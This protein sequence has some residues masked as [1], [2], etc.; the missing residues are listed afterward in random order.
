MNSNKYE[1][2]IRA[3][4]NGVEKVPSKITWIQGNDECLATPCYKENDYLVV[5]LIPDCVGNACI[6]GYLHFDDTCTNCE[7]EHFKRCFCNT[8]ADCPDCSQCDENYG[9]CVDQCKEGE[10]CKDDACIECDENTPCPNNQICI[11][12]HCECPPNMFKDGN[13]CVE[14][15]STTNL[16]K[17][18]ECINGVITPKCDKACIELTGECVD[19]IGSGDCLDRTDGKNCCSDNQCDCCNGF[20]WDNLLK[21]CVPSCN[22]TTCNE[23]ERCTK[24]GCQPIQ[25]PEGYKCYK[26]ECVYW[27]CESVSCDNGAECGPECGC[28][29]FEGVKQCVPCYILECNGLCEQALGCKCNGTKCESS[30]NCKETYC[31]NE[32]PCEDP[33][34]TC[35]D[36]KCVDCSNFPCVDEGGCSSYDNCGCNE[37]NK[38]EGTGCEGGLTLKKEEDCTSTTGC[39]LKAEF[40]VKACKCDP[41]VF[42]TKNTVTCTSTSDAI[43]LKVELFKKVNGADIPYSSYKTSPYFA[44]DELVSTQIRTVAEYQYLKDGKFYSYSGTVVTSPMPSTGIMNNVISNLVLNSSHIKKTITVGGVSYPAKVTIKV[45]ADA[46]KIQNANCTKYESTAKIAEYVLDYS[47]AL[48]TTDTCNKINTTYKTEQVISVIDDK[49]AKRPR[50]TWYRSNTSTFEDDEFIYD[51]TYNESGW[52]RKSFGTL[53]SGKWIDEINNTAKFE[54]NSKGELL[55]NYNY[56]VKADCGCGTKVDSLQ[57]VHFC[58]PKDFT[59]TITPCDKKIVINPFSVCSINDT[60]PTSYSIPTECQVK[61]N[62][63]VLLDSGAVIKSQLPKS[64]LTKTYPD[65]IVSAKI[66]QFNSGGIL[67]EEDYCTFMLTVPE[68]TLP[69]PTI[70]VDCNSVTDKFRVTFTQTSP[71]NI[72]KVEVLANGIKLTPEIFKTTPGLTALYDKTISNSHLPTGEDPQG[73]VSGV[74]VKLQARVTFSNGCSK[75]IDLTPCNPSLTVTENPSGATSR[76]NCPQG[77]QGVELDSYLEGFDMS[78]PVLFTISGGTLTEPL[79]NGTGTF[80]NLGAGTYTVVATQGALTSTATKTIF[81]ATAPTVTLTSSIC[82]GETGTL[83]ITAPA[84]SI[85]SVMGPTGSISIPPI[86]QS[87]VY[88]ITGLTASGTYTITGGIDNNNQT[89]YPFTWT[90]NMVL[91]GQVLNPIFSPIAYGNYCVD[92]PIEIS[93]IDG[94]NGKIYNIAAISGYITDQAGNNVTQMISGQTYFYT[95]TSIGS[96]AVQIISIDSTCDTLLTTPVTRTFITIVPAPNV[97][98]IVVQCV[99]GLYNVSATVTV[100]SG[101]ISS[102]LISGIPA[103]NIGSTYSVTGVPYVENLIATSSNGCIYQAILPIANCNCPS[104]TLTITGPIV[105]L[106]GDQLITLTALPQL[107]PNIATG[108]WTYQW[109][110]AGPPNCN[111]CTPLAIGAQGS[112]GSQPVE[113]VVNASGSGSYFLRV[114]NNLNPECTYTSNTYSY[115]VDNPPATPIIQHTPTNITVGNS[116]TFNTGYSNYS[117]YAWYLNG[118]TTPVSTNSTYTFTPTLSGNY[119]ISVTVSNGNSSCTATASDS[120]EVT[121]ECNKIGIFNVTNPNTTC[122]T[123][124][125]VNLTNPDNI[126]F[127]WVIVAVN[128]LTTSDLVGLTGSGTGNSF[129]FDLTTPNTD[130]GEDIDN[131]SFVFSYTLIGN[132][133][134]TQPPITIPW[135]Y[136]RCDKGP[137]DLMLDNTSTWRDIFATDYTLA[138]LISTETLVFLTDI[139]INT[140]IGN[141]NTVSNKIYSNSGSASPEHEYRLYHDHA[142]TGCTGIDDDAKFKTAVDSWFGTSRTVTSTIADLVITVQNRLNAIPILSGIVVS[143][144]SGNLRFSNVPCE[145]QQIVGTVFYTNS[146]DCVFTD[147][148]KKNA[149]QYV[150]P[151]C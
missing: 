124:A 151:S 59:Y 8:D 91:G 55:S 15:T 105:P 28:V 144:S 63:E 82:P 127:N 108:A 67:T 11:N 107:N 146:T 22:E 70:T 50:F 66:I 74:I 110:D 73:R 147:I 94:V 58:C 10:F 53:V 78:Q 118:G 98:N 29:E 7:P 83:T 33:N 60:L 36:N 75:I 27:P 122:P 143:N 21:Q 148:E 97:S 84:G 133:D 88:N 138:S 106:C 16:G 85:F 92:I 20:E 56:L 17:C 51:G 104:A 37:D 136:T 9:I 125:T 43:T 121:S 95:P 61:Y 47:S 112:W 25:C 13:R 111:N 87:G 90:G 6:E 93:I 100:S 123:Q 40:S 149:S 76:L 116:V 103:T 141:N 4:V 102:V 2:R 119:T 1:I 86:P 132:E 38:C 5:K 128:E 139:T 54:D 135:E 42:K 46:T 80:T 79:T 24:D 150:I 44:D 99:D 32:N 114:I 19:C 145:V 35:Y 117:T 72:D 57:K 140:K 65:A 69:T 18:F 3:T 48:A 52:F 62:L 137:V 126:S 71:L 30:D 131:I 101:T 39:K 41:I 68:V 120:F 31:D 96:N 142:T 34:C 49:S 113:L 89:C 45:F 26:G 129:T 23:C 64:G 109:Y 130:P 115:T 14:C 134:C 12:G 81:D 77:G